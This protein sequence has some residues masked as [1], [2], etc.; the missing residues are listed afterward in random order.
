MSY[1]FWV[2]EKKFYEGLTELEEQALRF[3]L[4]RN[5]F[6]MGI[7]VIG[8]TLGHVKCI[9]GLGAGSLLPHHLEITYKGEKYAKN[10]DELLTYIEF[11]ERIFKNNFS[12]K[13]ILEWLQYSANETEDFEIEFKIAT[14]QRSD[15]RRSTSG[16]ANYKS[17]IL[18]I[19]FDDSGRL[20]G[21]SN[22]DDER[23][24]IFD[25]L[26]DLK[27]L[28]YKTRVVKDKNKN[29]GLIEMVARGKEPILIGETMIIRDG[30]FYRTAKHKEIIKITK[31]MESTQSGHLW[32]KS[33]RKF[34]FT[35]SEGN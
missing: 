11:D 2:G 25:A 29:K 24:K 31:L 33:L 12:D 15:L 22:P 34:S 30:S 13:T 18:A 23:R 32:L 17:G 16:F 5:Q 28:D 6:A 27:N 10:T 1:E 8:E 26:R 3:K 9:N 7:R 19:G 21:L 4:S 14:P 20:I 35:K